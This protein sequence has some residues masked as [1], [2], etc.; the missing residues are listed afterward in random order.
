MEELHQWHVAKCTAHS[1][2]ER[3]L[4]EAI[5]QADPCVQAMVH[6]TEEGKKVA[7]LGGNKHYAVFRR[8]LDEEIV[9]PPLMQL[10]E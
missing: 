6:E 2:F 10:W 5:L 1:S 4:D 3:I 8:R 9:R 7:R